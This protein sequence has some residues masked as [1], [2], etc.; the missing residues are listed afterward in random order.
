MGSAT[1]RLSEETRKKLKEMSKRT[2]QPMQAI[3][4]QAVERYRRERFLDEANAAFERLQK[5]QEA[6]Q[7]ELDERQAWNVALQDD[8]D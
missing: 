3:L 8:L 5:D 4:D 1:V 2:G 6:W 7:S